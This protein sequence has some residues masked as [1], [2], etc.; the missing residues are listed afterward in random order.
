M[1]DWLV[2]VT[3]ICAP[4]PN[5]PCHVGDVPVVLPVPVN[6]DP[7][8]LAVKISPPVST[9]STNTVASLAGV[10]PPKLVPA[11]T[12]ASPTT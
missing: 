1:Y 5:P 8:I 3:F 10:D 4:C 9:L 11:T 2:F 6:A 12:I 7:L